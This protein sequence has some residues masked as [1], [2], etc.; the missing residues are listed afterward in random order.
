LSLKPTLATLAVLASALPALSEQMTFVLDSERSEVRILLG[1]TLHT[2]PGSAPIGP[3]TLTWDTESGE[4]SGQVVIQ[5]A[6]LDT[7]I[8]ARNAK[9]HEVVL[10][11]L[12]HPEI[13]F[14]A[15]GFELR[16]PGDDEMRFVL[17]GTLTLVGTA[18]EIEFESHARRRGDDSWKVRAP[19]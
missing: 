16:Q 4:A 17:K 9:M 8:D 6:D 13:I 2:V 18:H 7:G 3:A 10:K 5:S 1:A 11:T 12:E 19:A 14:E 15:T